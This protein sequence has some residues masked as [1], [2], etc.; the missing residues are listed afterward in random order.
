[1]ADMEQ[2]SRMSQGFQP[3]VGSGGVRPQLPYEGVPGLG[4]T[5]GQMVAPLVVP[6]LNAGMA[7]HGYRPYGNTDQNMIDRNRGLAM[8][9]SQRKL[10]SAAAKEEQTAW[11]DSMAQ[12]WK[13]TRAEGESLPTTGGDLFH[14]YLYCIVPA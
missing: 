3:M 8:S 7:A 10:T 9:N 12:V 14:P 6:A 4:S 5:L 2:V 13:R 1:M 11:M